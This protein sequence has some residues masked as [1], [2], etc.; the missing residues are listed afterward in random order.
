MAFSGARGNL[1]QVRQLVGMRGLMS[2]PNGQI[3][4]I[5]I[6]HNFREGLTITDYIMSAYGAR[7][8]VVDTSL[9]T[10]DSGYLTRRLI[11]VVQDV[12]IS[13]KNCLT[14]RS[15]YIYTS[16]N[17]DNFFYKI[18]GRTSAEDIYADETLIIKKNT[19]ITTELA[20]ILVRQKLDSIRI[21]SPLTCESIRSICQNC[22]GW[23]LAYG[24]LIALGEAVGIIAAQSI[25]EPGTQLTMR[26]FHNGGIFTADLSRQIRANN[27]GIFNL[28]LKS[29][30]KAIRTMY[31]NNISIL[32]KDTKCFIVNYKNFT[33]TI[34]LPSESS[35]FVKDKSFIKKGDLIAE[36]A[37]KN[38]QTTRAKKNII[39]SNSG[40]I[41]FAPKSEIIWIVDGDVYYFAYRGLFNL[42]HLDR[43][44]KKKANFSSIKLKTYHDGILTVRENEFS[45][46]IELIIITKCRSRL[47]LPLLWAK[48]SER[49]VFKI[50]IDEYY[51]QPKLSTV[52]EIP[53]IMGYSTSE[54]YETETG[55]YILYPKKSFVHHDSSC[56][57]ECIKKNGKILFM[58]IEIHVIEASNALLAVTNNTQ[59]PEPTS[60]YPITEIYGNRVFTLRYGFI[61]T[62]ED[63]NFVSD[64]KIKLGI[65]W[66]YLNLKRNSIKDIKK[67][68]NKIFFKNEI[69]FDDVLIEY[70]TYIESKKS[71]KFRGF[72]LWPIQEFNIAKP[73]GLLKNKSD[74]DNLIKIKSRSHL[75][76][77]AHKI[78][79]QSTKLVES[80][81]CIET[82]QKL[83]KINPGLIFNIFQN[84]KKK[85][86]FY[87]CIMHKQTIDL[88]TLITK[89]LND[90]SVNV[91]FSTKNFE[92]V[93]RH[94]IL[95]FVSVIYQQTGKV[96]N[97]KNQPRKTLLIRNDN[98]KQFYL[99]STLF[100]VDK[101]AMLRLGNIIGPN[102]NVTCSGQITLKTP[103]KLTVHQST[104][105]F[106]TKNTSI[107]KKNGD[108]IKKGELLGIIIFEQ[109]VTGDI[110]KGLP[111][112]E[113]ILEARIPKI[114]VNFFQ[115]FAFIH[116]DGRILK[117]N[118]WSE[119]IKYEKKKY[120]FGQYS[121]IGKLDQVLIEGSLNP[122]DLLNAYFKY[123]EKYGNNYEA[124]YLSFKNIQV[125]LIE[126]VQ[127]V[128]NSQGVTIAD[129]HLET[130]LKRMTSKV[131]I[132]NS[133]SSSL[134]VYE[135]IELKQINYINNVLEKTSKITA[136]YEPILLG[137]TKAA[138]IAESFLSAASFQETSKI[139][140]AAAIEGKSDWLRGVKENVIL[141]RLIP[142]G[143]GFE[144]LIRKG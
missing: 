103:F 80:S 17:K 6:I 64:V 29:Q 47:F 77:K 26:T 59:L 1:S 8:G 113:E 124:S 94:A 144:N 60:D 58:P 79:N 33:A 86:E 81:I 4:D 85:N 56:G 107:I 68:N 74:F 92:Y 121:Y 65:I 116:N 93:E 114:P 52:Y 43:K 132:V 19:A 125:L 130:I 34:K 112:V 35:I 25:G 9:R 38:R 55:G 135:L 14:N 117:I 138:L 140:T 54:D 91:S 76:C 111:K 3:M 102:L 40:E 119:S 48:D 11:D 72:L 69:V 27:T 44:I 134:L 90:E 66:E 5:P 28:N 95:G 87:F 83:Y 88:W 137:I 32:E 106:I 78:F 97:I 36:L 96:T 49:L 120:C 108:F 98:F 7:K 71:Y 128:Y 105:F 122:H 110:I 136:T 15:I 22:Y 63:K 21:N 84:Y 46:Y 100:K 57:Q 2:D 141:G 89:K 20:N 139:L 126:K 75:R 104:P 115:D 101:N 30:L 24:N 70:L 133:G 129:K 16:N 73:K 13:E 23:N 50:S 123:Y 45:K 142:A 10:A 51:T 67:L 61:E 41:I 42:V 109:I 131:K 62:N 12:T 53:F 39:T 37:I 118:F 99:E 143:S 127:Q 31:G 18:L 82:N